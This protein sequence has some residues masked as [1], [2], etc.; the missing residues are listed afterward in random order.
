MVKSNSLLHSVEPPAE[1]GH[2]ELGNIRIDFF[3]SSVHSALTV[4]QQWKEGSLVLLVLNFKFRYQIKHFL[5]YPK[6][7]MKMFTIKCQVVSI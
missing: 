1:L 5:T 4:I 3:P 7:Q 2:C 6:L